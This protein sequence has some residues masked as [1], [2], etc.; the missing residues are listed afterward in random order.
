[1]QNADSYKRIK[2]LINNPKNLH[3][4]LFKNT[5]SM[6]SSSISNSKSENNL[7]KS[8]NKKNKLLNKSSMS[9]I[10]KRGCGNQ[11]NDY[12]LLTNYY[13]YKNSASYFSKYNQF[14]I[15]NTYKKN[16]YYTSSQNQNTLP[17]I[18]LIKNNDSESNDTSNKKHHR[19]KSQ[20]DFNKEMTTFFSFRKFPYSN[21]LL[22]K[23]IKKLNLTKVNTNNSNFLRENKRVKNLNKNNFRPNYKKIFNN[24]LV[25]KDL[26]KFNKK[27]FGGSSERILCNSKTQ[28]FI[29]HVESDKITSNSNT[30]NNVIKK[31]I[32]KENSKK[33]QDEEKNFVNIEFNGI[34]TKVI[35]KLPNNKDISEKSDAEDIDFHKIM[36]HP[37]IKESYGYNFFKNVKYEYKIKENPFEDKDLI[38]NI[39]NLIINPNTKLF[40]NENLIAGA[41]YYKR[42]NNNESNKN[43]KLLSKQGY[44]KMKN[45]IKRHLKKRIEKNLLNIKR[46]KN[47]LGILIEKNIKKL[48]KNEEEIFNGEL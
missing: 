42:T 1:M 20:Q 3:Q 31:V 38:Y 41:D 39:K 9:L 7:I 28:Y 11:T 44:K 2:I 8:R 15:L 47:D 30:N 36:K 46:I 26:K 6:N 45:S 21:F 24:K 48:K 14:L 22:D 25:S 40:R 16:T 34:L 13:R 17:D 27:L 10:I 18:Y 35:T 43:Y 19:N 37:F 4:S 5:M 32:I 29:P 33:N 12:N 23:G